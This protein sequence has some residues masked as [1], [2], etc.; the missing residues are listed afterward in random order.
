MRKRGAYVHV[1]DPE[2]AW[3]TANISQDHQPRQ[4][5][6]QHRLIAEADQTQQSFDVVVVGPGYPI[7]SDRVEDGM[8]LGERLQP[9]FALPC[10]TPVVGGFRFLDRICD[11]LL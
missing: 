6:G 1:E 9:P 8:S 4:G 11:G 3:R 7:T 2:L 5:C 10:E